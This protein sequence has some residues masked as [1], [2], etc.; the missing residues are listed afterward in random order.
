MKVLTLM[1]I[2]GAA[3]AGCHRDP[4]GDGGS[5]DR[6]R[7]MDVTVMEGDGRTALYSGL[8]IRE[9]LAHT[10]DI[11]ASGS[12]PFLRVRVPPTMV[13]EV[14]Q[15]HL[16]RRILSLEA[17]SPSVEI[18]YHTYDP[19]SE[20]ED[21]NHCVSLTRT[22]NLVLTPG[23][24]W[25]SGHLL[26]SLRDDGSM[27]ARAHIIK[28][29]GTLPLGG[30]EIVEGFAGCSPDDPETPDCPPLRYANQDPCR[31]PPLPPGWTV[32]AL[33]GQPTD[34]DVLCGRKPPSLDA[35]VD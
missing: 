16:H 3:A 31:W 23:Q 35:G 25:L 30:A 6:A 27:T 34:L 18:T 12:P 4:C 13:A 1:L 32:V 10:T 19:T 33:M 11:D 5:M 2:W 14:Q 26:L 24:P 22:Q 28:H 7:Y 15:A 29:S 17:P 21:E 20:A 9:R 8:D